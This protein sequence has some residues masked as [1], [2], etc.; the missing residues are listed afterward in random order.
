[1][2]HYDECQVGW[3]GAIGFG[4]HCRVKLGDDG[5]IGFAAC[6]FQVFRQFVWWDV[7]VMSH[8]IV[9]QVFE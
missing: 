5:V 6:G 2:R 8:L 9:A 7:K 1:M 3:R 4:D